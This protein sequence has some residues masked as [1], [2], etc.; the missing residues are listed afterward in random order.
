MTQRGYC[1]PRCLHMGR[2]RWVVMVRGWFLVMGA[3]LVA[4]DLDADGVG[5]V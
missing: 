5:V 1:R 3:V 2:Q 4:V